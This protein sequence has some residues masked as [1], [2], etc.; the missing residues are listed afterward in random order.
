MRH[1]WVDRAANIEVARVDKRGIL[2]VGVPEIL[3]R[4]VVDEAVA[5]IWPRPRLHTGGMLPVEHPHILD[6]DVADEALFA[7]VLPYGS[8]GLAMRA[9]AVHGVNV[10]V[11]C[12]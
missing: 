10:Q 3:E 6:V 1:V 11:C 5:N 4:D 7:R 2:V 8:H 9:V 12:V